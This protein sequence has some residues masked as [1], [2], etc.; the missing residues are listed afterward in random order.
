MDCVGNILSTSLDKYTRGQGGGEVKRMID[1]VLV[2][3]DICC[4]V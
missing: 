3:R 4:T 2:K 1:L